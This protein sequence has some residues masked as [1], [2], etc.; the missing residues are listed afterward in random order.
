MTFAGGDFKSAFYC[1][2]I[3]ADKAGYIEYGA[4]DGHRLSLGF[5]EYLL[6][7]NIAAWKGSPYVKVEVFNPNNQVLASTIVK[8]APNMDG[9]T[10]SVNGSTKVALSFYS[11]DKGNYRVRFSPVA[12]Q[13]GNGGVWEEA[14]VANVSLISLGNPLAFQTANEVPAG[15]TIYNDGEKV[16]AGMAGAGPRIFT[17]SSAGQLPTALYVRQI[18]SSRAGYAE[19]GTAQNYGMSLVAGRYTLSY[20][21]AAWQG[22][23][24]I[25]C[26]VFDRNNHSLGS[27]IIKLTKNL[28]KNLSVGTYDANYGVVNFT[29]PSTDYY[30]FR[31]TPVLDEWGNG[32][33]WLEVLF[34]HIKIQHA[35][36]QSR[37]MTFGTTDNI[38]EFVGAEKVEDDP[39]YSLSGVKLAPSLNGASLPAGVYIH[40]G[41]KIVVK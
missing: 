23:P 1:R 22:T 3:A 8:A 15:W 18:S 40:K 28:D 38:E 37:A 7:C 30:H 14:L 36:A 2:E 5:G 31:W 24:Y 41:K 6:T 19:Y 10:G 13:N 39:V 11:M 25:K 33:D 34:G 12:D 16:A 4:I 26:E 21:A 17:L 35:T 27:Q 9:A 29:A 32:G 20:F